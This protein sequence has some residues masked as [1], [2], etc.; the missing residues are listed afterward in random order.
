[1]GFKIINKNLYF[2]MIDFIQN[3]SRSEHTDAIFD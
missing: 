2:S 1:M 3:F